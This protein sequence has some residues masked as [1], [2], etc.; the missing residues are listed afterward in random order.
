MT[1]EQE[2][3]KNMKKRGRLYKFK[4]KYGIRYSALY[5]AIKEA[6][7][8]D[9]QINTIIQRMID[10]GYLRKSKDAWGRE[11]EGLGFNFIIEK[12]EN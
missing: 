11:C 5:C 3:Y 10:K 6:G 9:E 4:G 2:I 1:K 8:T 12:W 7:Y